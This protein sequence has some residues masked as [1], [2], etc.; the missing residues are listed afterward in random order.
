MLLTATP[1]PELD[2]L[3]DHWIAEVRFVLRDDLLAVCLQG[4][5]AV[6]DHDE[7]SDC[8]FVV[9]VRAP[10]TDAQVAALQAVHA[11]LHASSHPWRAHLEG[12]Y[13]PADVLRSCDRRGEPLWYMDRGHR[14]LAP[15]T[16]C[17]TAVVRQTV[18]QHGVHLFGS[19]PAS[20]VDP[21]PVATLR[22]E[23][24]TTMLDWGREILAR[25]E[26]W[27][28]RFYQGFIVLN[29]CR[30]WCDLVTGTVGSKRRGAGWA[31]TRLDPSWSDLIDRAWATRRDTARTWNLPADPDDYRRTLGLLALIMDAMQT[32]SEQS[33]GHGWR[34]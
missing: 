20:L 12:S 3:L 30:A 28:V 8:D 2:G 21:V 24:A 22:R 9:A 17:N 13:F 10:L 31:K 19:P 33:P 29:Y 1:F 34:S 4:S 23:I 16:H 11:R 5:L 18:R 14:Q 32:V 26:A 15:G 7:H 27:A 25:P 6:G